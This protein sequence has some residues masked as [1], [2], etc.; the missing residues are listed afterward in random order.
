[1]SKLAPFSIIVAIDAA[2]G[3][4][5]KGAIPWSSREDMKFFRDVTMGRR[6]NSNAVI[7]GRNTYES[8]PVEHR[9]LVGRRC[10]VISRTW[11]QEEHTDVRVYPGLVDALAGAGATLKSYDDVF[12]VGGEGLYREA[13][14][15]FAYLCKRIYVT[16]FKSDYGCDQFFPFDEVRNLPAANDP[17]KTRDY[18][19]YTYAP[20]FTHD[21]NQYLNALRAVSAEGEAKKDGTT[22]LFGGVKMQFDLRDRLPVITSKRV[23]YDVLIKELM[24]FLTGSTDAN[25]SGVKTWDQATRKVNLEKLGLSWNEGDMGPTYPFQWR[26]FGVEYQGC[27]VD[28]EGY[29][30]DQITELIKTIRDDPWS[31]RMILTSWNP[32][33]VDQTTVP[34]RHVM[35]QFNVSGDRK[36]LDAQVYVR[37][38]DMFLEV[39]LT[40]TFYSLFVYVVAHVTNLKP[41]KLVVTVGD[42]YVHNVHGDHVKRQVER[43]PRPFPT[44]SFR[45]AHRLHE[46]KDFTANS[47]IVEN[48]TSWAAISVEPPTS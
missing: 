32:S 13:I 1:M 16:K 21:E 23:L 25:E 6:E 39:P 45:E 18:A 41:R 10:I 17:V 30:T 4:A 2:N 36:W 40:I 27:D 7:M 5:K 29:G 31:R 19:R 28:Y 24:F 34:P 14:S 37:A 15:N 38:G 22:S 11:R 33:Q 26:R 48:Y 8:I 9:P 42:A 20:N 43:T 47:F 35:V 46:L 44:L 12:L 3:M